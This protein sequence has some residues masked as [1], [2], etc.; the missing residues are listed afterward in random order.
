MGQ[1]AAV[2]VRGVGP[3]VGADFLEGDAGKAA[4]EA[5]HLR[6]PAAE[7]EVAHPA[8]LEA[9]RLEGDGARGDAAVL[10]AQRPAGGGAEVEGQDGAMPQGDG[11]RGGDRR[12]ACV[13]RRH[14]ESRESHGVSERGSSW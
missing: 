3:G 11:R 4:G 14:G 5:G 2:E 6:Q 8:A 13:R 9:A 10:A 7:A 12:T 1:E